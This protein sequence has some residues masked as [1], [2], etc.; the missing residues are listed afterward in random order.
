MSAEAEACRRFLDEMGPTYRVRAAKTYRVAVEGANGVPL[1]PCLDHEAK[2]HAS[3]EPHVSAYLE[4]AEGGELHEV[5]CY[6][7]RSVLV[8]DLVSTSGEHGEASYRRLRDFL[9]K[10]FPTYAVHEHHPSWLRG[11][12]RAIDASRAQVKLRDVLLASDWERLDASLERLRAVAGL[13]EKESRVASWGIRTAGTPILAAAG[14]LIYVLLE[15][16]A[17]SL[18]EWWTSALR[19]SFLALLG[20]ILMYVGLKAVHLTEI[21]NRVWKRSAEYGLILDERRRQQ[22]TRGS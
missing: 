2:L 20:G 10:K 17:G 1:L 6:P 15:L 14:V 8:V 9:S 5:A 7:S 11:D 4:E 16:C 13:M 18:G 3:Y 19:Y 22:R 21:S 12:R